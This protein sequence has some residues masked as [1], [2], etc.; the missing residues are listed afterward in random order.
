MRDFQAALVAEWET[1][2]PTGERTDG[3]G[4]SGKRSLVP[5]PRSPGGSVVP[6][7][8][9]PESSESS[10][11]TPGD[12]GSPKHESESRPPAKS[13]DPMEE[14]KRLIEARVFDAYCDRRTRQEIVRAATG[15]GAIAREDVEADVGAILEREGIADEEAL[16]GELIA[17]LLNWTSAKRVLSKRRYDD[18][19]GLFCRPR[20]GFSRGLERRVFDTAVDEFCAAHGVKKRSRW[21]W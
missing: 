3:G 20:R 5:K 14:V 9:G 2:F 13:G 21:P 17:T 6:K 1:A 16:L 8:G 7:E 19:M 18:A 12:L 15:G 4:R 11:G 10:R